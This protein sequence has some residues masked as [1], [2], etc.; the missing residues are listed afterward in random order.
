MK[1]LKIFKASA[2]SG[3]TF[4]LAVEYI[5]L[6][7]QNP[8][9]YQNIL[10]VTF[11]NKATA[12]MKMRIL[13]QLNGIA[14]SYVNSQQYFDKVKEAPEIQALNISDAELRRR[15]GVAMTNLLHD[16]HRFKVVTIDSFFQGIVR[17]LAYELD[18]TANLRVDLNAKEALAEAVSALVNS[19]SEGTPQE[20]QKQLLNLILDF[21]NERINEDKSWDVF[22]SVNKFGMHVFNENYLKKNV[23]ERLAMGDPKGLSTLKTKLRTRKA[24]AI[25]LINNGALALQGALKQVG[26]DDTNLAGKS[27]GVWGLLDKLSTIKEQGEID[28]IFN[29]TFQKC[30]AGSGA[31]IKDTTHHAWID[32]YGIPFL[33]AVRQNVYD[34]GTCNAVLEHINEMMLLNAINEKLREMNHEAN[35]FLLADT[36]HFLRN[37]IDE[38]DVPFIYERTGTRYTHIMIDEFQDTSELQWDNFQ[39]LL[40]NCLDQ[41]QRCLIVGDV[42]QSIYR[43]RNSDWGIF[44]GIEESRFKHHVDV[45]PLDTN[46]RSAEYV[47]RFNND[48]FKHAVKTV[49]D[50]YQQEFGVPSTEIAKAY[51]D[52]AQQ[53]DP[54]QAGKGYVRIDDVVDDQTDDPTTTMLNAVAQTLRDL[55]AAGVP[56]NKIAILVRYSK[57]G[58]S[59]VD[60]LAQTMPE[61]K[62][63]SNEAYTLGNSSLLKLLIQAL[64]VLLNPNNRLERVLLAVAYQTE[65][66]G[67][68]D[69]Q[70]WAEQMMLL[71]DEDME[72]YLPA[73]FGAEQRTVLADLPLYELCERLYD[74]FGMNAIDGQ[75]TYLFCFYDQLL[76][77]LQDKPATLASLVAYWEETMQNKEVQ[78]T[79]TD[80]VQIMTIHKSKGLEFHSVIAP[81]FDWRADGL[82]AHTKNYVWCEPQQAPF[83]AVPILPIVFNKGLGQTDFRD[84][85]QKEVL[86]QLVDNLNLMYVAY[87]RAEQNLVVLTRKKTSHRQ[88][89]EFTLNTIIHQ[90]IEAFTPQDVPLNT[91]EIN[92]NGV[93]IKRSEYATLKAYEPSAKG[94][95]DGNVFTMP[96]KT[97]V[98]PFVYHPLTATFM[99]SHASRQFLSS[100]EADE[101]QLASQHYVLLGKVV[102]RVLEYVETAADTASALLRVEGEGLF[103]DE[104]MRQSVQS[105]I[106]QAIAQPEVAEWFMPGWRV[107][108]ECAIYY[109]DEHGEVKCC[110]P[111][112]VLCQ[113]QRTIVV[114]YKTSQQPPSPALRKTYKEQVER[115]V[116]HLKNMGY[117]NIEGYVWYICQSEIDAVKP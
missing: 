11:T 114:D 94:T 108:N 44:N 88:T 60:Y 81:F 22:A 13:G 4:T 77:F 15:A 58:K 19:L 40:K 10:A 5:K 46:H 117:Q 103:A 43:W 79:G 56:Q 18:L 96:S 107:I 69:P 64:R 26:L 83:N 53:V 12:E 72:Q 75:D 76:M 25:K 24:D 41:E 95:P 93:T 105:L 99:Q 67:V 17:E 14:H 66:L 55:L 101:A 20:K 7:I 51:S 78:M 36:G 112:R 74:V 92:E 38:S 34:I 50:Y 116:N 73:A 57:A 110:R 61:V 9:A 30:E 37:M 33:K 86:K 104:Q 80:G 42:K 23:E 48:L 29:A 113:G 109:R 49:Q 59:I 3:K 70:R 52:V 87:T 27:R 68:V 2:G 31:W 91:T 8:F 45:V 65:V 115:Y 98:V 35:R 102:H 84:D 47:V 39:P 82:D 54:K 106:E 63:V 71:S 62:L 32:A 16:Y 100:D 6:L 21:I 89:S 1:A 28:K 85:Y 97:Q 90:A 111:D